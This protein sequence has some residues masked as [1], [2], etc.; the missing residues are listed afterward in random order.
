M[1]RNQYLRETL[2]VHVSAITAS[3]GR[4]RAGPSRRC[5]A[6]INI[7]IFMNYLNTIIPFITKMYMC[8]SIYWYIFMYTFTYIYVSDYICR[9]C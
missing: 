1:T 8:C 2:Q 9:M 6:S 7:V 5:A 4:T 3:S